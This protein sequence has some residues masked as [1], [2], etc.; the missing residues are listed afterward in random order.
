VFGLAL[1]PIALTW[2]VVA[3][4]AKDSP[5][6]PA[7]K[8]LNEYMSVVKQP[9]TLWFCLFYGITF[10]GFVGLAYFLPT[11]FKDQYQMDKVQSG[12][13]AAMCVFAGS[14][15]RPVGGYLADRF[16]GVRMLVFL[17][18]LIGSLGI[19]VSQMLPVFGETVALIVLMAALGLGNG[20]VFQLVPQRFPRQI[21]V[22]TG[23]VGAAGGLGGFFLNIA[24]GGLKQSMV[25]IALMLV[26]HPMWRRAGWLS[27]GGRAVLAP[28]TAD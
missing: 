18:G 4:F 25:C 23:I 17:Y 14:F 20:S 1:I 28:A 19:V 12:N 24:L 11:F 7:P 16:G 3:M 5:Q 8:S 2:I 15:M 6:R 10:G 13:L 26:L 21:G 27:N 9:D 22:I